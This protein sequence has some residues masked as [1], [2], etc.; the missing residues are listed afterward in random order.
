MPGAAGDLLLLEGDRDDCMDDLRP[1]RLRPDLALK[2]DLE[3]LA[4]PPGDLL[5]YLCRV[6]FG[7]ILL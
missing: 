6:P 4:L 5:R 2:G 3:Y 7:V 1:F